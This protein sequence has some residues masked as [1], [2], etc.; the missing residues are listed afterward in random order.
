MKYIVILLLILS[1]NAV[2][3]DKIYFGYS[4]HH[5]DRGYTLSASKRFVHY[6]ET[7]YG[8]GCDGIYKK[9]DAVLYKNSY[10]KTSLSISTTDWFFE[11]KHFRAGIQYGAV[12][13]YKILNGWEVMPYLAPKIDFDIGRLTV[14]TALN[15]DVYAVAFK[16][17]LGK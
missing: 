17:T 8:F 14:S 7:N 10:R 13:G 12:T 6:N 5:P 11:R 1:S 3:C 16:F 2:A 4:S 9:V 15:P